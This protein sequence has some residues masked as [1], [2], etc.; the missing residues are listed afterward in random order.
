[1]PP[2]RGERGCNLSSSTAAPSPRVK[3][4]SR[5][6]SAPSFLSGQYHFR[7]NIPPMLLLLFFVAIDSND[8]YEKDAVMRSSPVCTAVPPVRGAQGCAGAIHKFGA[9]L[10]GACDVKAARHA[11][12]PLVN[13]ALPLDEHIRPP[14]PISPSSYTSREGH[15]TIRLEIMQ[16]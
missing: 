4:R 7:H 9:S 10:G 15:R 12:R 5:V 6:N 11:Q 2:F 14:P 8:H 3:T 16:I 1:M 13:V